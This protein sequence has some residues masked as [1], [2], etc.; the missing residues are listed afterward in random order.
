MTIIDRYLARTVLVYTALVMGVLMTLGA[1]FVFIGQQDDI[2][3]GAYTAADAFVYSLLSMPQQFF[4]LLPIGSLLGSLLGLGLLARSSE[5]IVIRASGVSLGRMSAAVLAAGFILVV[6]GVIVGEYVGPATQQYARQYKVFS[7][8]ADFSVAGS[9]SAWVKDGNNIVQL[10]RQTGDAMFGGV[11][12]F[13]FSSDKRLAAVGR[14]STAIVGAGERWQFEGYAETA[15][16]DGGTRVSRER[17][18][19][20]ETHVSPEFLGL[21][22]ILPNQMRTLQLARYLGHLRENQLDTRQIEFALWARIARTLSIAVI[23]LLALPFCFGSMRSAGSGAKTVIGVLIGIGFYLLQRTL[24]SSAQVFNVNP[25][26]LAW[27]PLVLLTVATTV[28][29]RRTQ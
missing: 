13:R 21:A 24:E 2:G 7:K 22:V 15:F 28:A 5:I 16:V 3:V 18:R 25:I 4:E 17:Q 1:L 11:S 19:T 27:T 14:A 29:L 23:V 10:D 12:L 6:V 26:L 9:G 8:F 20:F